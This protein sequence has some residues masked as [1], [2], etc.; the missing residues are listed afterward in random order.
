MRANVDE[1]KS[2]EHVFSN[3]SYISLT[4]RVLVIYT[5]KRHTHSGFGSL[6][7]TFIS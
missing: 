1:Y 5:A 4:M 2:A 7:K 3:S 6:L